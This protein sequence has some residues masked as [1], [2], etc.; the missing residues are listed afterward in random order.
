MK[1]P[2]QDFDE[3]PEF[4]GDMGRFLRE[5]RENPDALAL[6]RALCVIPDVRDLSYD[7]RRAN[8]D[9]DS[10]VQ[11]LL[12]EAVDNVSIRDAFV[13]ALLKDHLPP[14]ESEP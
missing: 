3:L 10:I 2:D 11:M 13:A 7:P 5:L 9:H 4:P 14:P 6:M 8:L 1:S 12:Y